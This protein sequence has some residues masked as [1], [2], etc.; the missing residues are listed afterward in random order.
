MKGKWSDTKRGTVVR[1]KT[2]IEWTVM[3]WKDGLGTISRPG[4]TWTG[5]LEGD[6]TIVSQP[7]PQVDPE[8]TTATAKGL[9]AVKFGAIEIGKQG[10]GS[11]PWNTP[12]TFTDPGSALAHLRIFHGA[13]SESQSLTALLR[14]HDALHRPDAKASE[15]YEAHVHTPDYEGL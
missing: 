11:A 9:M 6:V 8:V 5:K 1:D 2:G 3:E 15:L 13:M 10:R 7:A 14:E 4:K 12:V